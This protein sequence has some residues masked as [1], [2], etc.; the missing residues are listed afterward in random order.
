MNFRLKCKSC[1]AGGNL[2]D[3]GPD[4]SFCEYVLRVRVLEVS[5]RVL[6]STVFIVLFPPFIHVCR[7]GHANYSFDLNLIP[8]V[9]ILLREIYPL[10]VPNES[11][12]YLRFT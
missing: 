12:M 2:R 11:A 7:Q 8:H 5:G 10:I 1:R 6:S 3:S 9:N 4:C